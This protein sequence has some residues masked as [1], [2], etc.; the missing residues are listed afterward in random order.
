MGAS[1][2]SAKESVR[3][4]RSA[5]GGER[6]SGLFD[7]SLAENCWIDLRITY[8]S[9]QRY[10]LPEKQVSRCDRAPVAVR[11]LGALPA[12]ASTASAFEQRFGTQVSRF[13]LGDPKSYELLVAPS[14]G[15]YWLLPSAESFSR[16]TGTCVILGDRRTK[17][18]V[19]KISVGDCFRLGSVGL[20]VSEI[21]TGGPGGHKI[22]SESA[23]E[24]LRND[25][26][27]MD[28]FAAAHTPG[29]RRRPGRPNLRQT[30]TQEEG[31]FCDD[32]EED[33][34]PDGN[35]EPLCYICFDGEDTEENPLVAPCKCRGDTQ[36]LHLKC[37]Q[38][39]YETNDDSHVCAV[40]TS[41]GSQNCPVC[42][43]KYKTHARLD[44]GKIISL[45]RR[46][47]EPPFVC[48]IVVTK[49]DAAAVL[50]QT[51][52]QLSFASVLN[53]AGTQSTRDLTIG[54]SQYCDM[55]LD[56][57]TISVRHASVRFSRENGFEMQDL[58]SSN[59]TLMYLQ[60]PWKLPMNKPTMIRVGLSTITFRPSCG[61]MT[62]LQR[63]RAKK[64]NASSAAAR[65]ARG[66]DELSELT[67]FFD[68]FMRGVRRRRKDGRK[69][70]AN[71]QAAGDDEV[72]GTTTDTSA[73]IP[74]L[75][76]LPQDLLAPESK[77]A[78]TNPDF[79]PRS[80]VGLG[81][82]G[83]DAGDDFEDA[84]SIHEVAPQKESS[85]RDS[86]AAA[87]ESKPPFASS[88][89]GKSPSRIT[90]APAP[91]GESPSRR[92]PQTNINN[93]GDNYE[94]F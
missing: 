7:S 80:G 79:S 62:R 34:P 71:A 54:R 22:M 60:K 17:S 12:D 5:T 39:W 20:V 8:A 26:E 77:A 85:R 9:S 35:D 23:W 37:L 45:R 66:E 89:R 88:S 67:E 13:S 55:P 94:N 83:S 86:D 84:M 49:H 29:S 69:A 64:R 90:V 75:L 63:W 32:T 59:G 72:K 46:E 76:E 16:H 1:A 14:M 31:V 91:L 52:F 38:K 57:R 93:G 44:N 19:Q 58:R 24:Y 18:R 92:R 27:R 74:L 6:S 53:A 47:L 30:E 56:Y 51:R 43:A 48:F 11:G 70:Q 3:Q 81:L 82:G 36:Y 42:K 15:G 21:H 50:F 41:T 10:K 4:T 65:A 33:D 78:A 73:D 87:C 28:S 40:Y 2:S 61:V 25:L 68:V